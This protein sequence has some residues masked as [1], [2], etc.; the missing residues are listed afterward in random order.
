MYLVYVQNKHKFCFKT[1]FLF[2][3]KNDYNITKGIIKVNK[4]NMIKNN[5][6]NIW[7]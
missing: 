4:V 6:V 5:T 7:I 1:S 2:A 3:W